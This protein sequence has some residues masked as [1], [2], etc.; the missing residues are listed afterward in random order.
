MHGN[1]FYGCATA[2]V[3]P[4]K[5]NRIDFDTL[6]RLIDWQLDSGV[7]ALAVLG[8]T[9]EPAAITQSERAAI[10]ECAVERCG[11]RAPLIVGTGS[12]DTRQAVRQSMEAARLGADALLV[13][14]PYYN[15]ANREGLIEH[16]T[17]IADS[18]DIP[19]IMY[20]VPARTGV[21][22]DALTVAELAKHPNLCAVKDASGSLRQ[23]TD[24]AHACGEGVA[25]YCGND[26][27]V[28]PAMALGARGVVSVAANVIPAEMHAMA[29][30]WLRG[31]TKRSLEAQLKYLPLIR[32]LFDEV[33][34]IPV[35]AA[36]AMLGRVE[37]SLRLP[38]CPLGDDKQ[39][40]LRRRMKDVGLIE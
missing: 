11:R 2:L 24:L 4:F 27:Q 5:G 30:D 10:I 28:V 13:V 3:T 38:L 19:V 29:A 21:N 35:K 37:N 34:P 14:T 16:Y 26:D 17:A 6:E 39:E 9:G 32:C 22:L 1:L 36:L 20:N 31:E 7:D 8:T 25:V 12:N 33:S 23:L 18:V 15:R 40:Q